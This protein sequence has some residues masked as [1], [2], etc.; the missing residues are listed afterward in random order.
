MNEE[1]PGLV[2]YDRPIELMPGILAPLV[3]YL[4][5]CRFGKVTG[6]SFIDSTASKVCHNRRIYWHK[7]FKTSAKRGKTSIKTYS[8]IRERT[9]GQSVLTQ[10]RAYLHLNFAL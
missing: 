10:R 8:E 7:T 9:D 2:S 1:F 6:V 4:K 5:R 3:I